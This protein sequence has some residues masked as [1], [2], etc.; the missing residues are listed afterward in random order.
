MMKERLM[1]AAMLVVIALSVSPLPVGAQAATM[2]TGGGTAT[3]CQFAMQVAIAGNG[4]ASGSFDLSMAGHLALTL[5]D[6][7]KLSLLHLRGQVSGGAVN[8][9]GS[10]T[11]SGT[12]TQ[13]M[14]VDQ[15]NTWLDIPVS[16][17]TTVRPG[18]A[19]VGGFTAVLMF[20]VGGVTLNEDVVTGMITIH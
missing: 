6:G 16:F 13:A 19:E 14:K 8:P 3:Q 1:L 18:G 4:V 12:G 17:T 20:P 11:F 10:I 15:S 7:T 2:V 5:P 9:D